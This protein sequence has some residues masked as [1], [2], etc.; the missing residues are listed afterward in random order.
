MNKEQFK[1]HVAE[2][3]TCEVGCKVERILFRKPG[4]SIELINFMAY[5]NTLVV[6]GDL[7]DG[8]YSVPRPQLMSFWAEVDVSYMA[9][10]LVDL[11]GGRAEC[12]EVWDTEKARN[13]L[14]RLKKEL[15][16]EVTE[17]NALLIEESG[18]SAEE[19][20]KE[21][22][23]EYFPD[24]CKKRGSLFNLMSWN[25]WEPEGHVDDEF[26][27]KSFLQEHGEDIWGQDWWE[28]GA[29]NVGKMRNP[30]I[31]VHSM[32]LKMAVA[33]LK[34]KGIELCRH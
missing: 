20:I 29:S 8:V 27:W 7:Y 34:A 2:Y 15:I 4:T 6:T 19:W 31:E 11:N 14:E 32:A 17:D 9:C 3:W 25:Y 30:I 26:S 18:K 5:G 16:A 22:T 33:Q 1:D 10:K 23:A 21:A 24:S 13:G 12:A 28:S